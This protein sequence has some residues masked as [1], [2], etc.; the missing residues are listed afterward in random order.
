MSS[1]A[2]ARAEVAAGQDRRVV[3]AV[4]RAVVDA[5]AEPVDRALAGHLLAVLGQVDLEQRGRDELRVA[6][7]GEV[8]DAR[9][10]EVGPVVLAAAAVR[11]A[12][13]LAVLDQE[14]VAVVGDA[15]GGLAP[16]VVVERDLREQARLRVG[17]ARG[18]LRRVDDQQ[19]VL[20]RRLLLADVGAGA[21]LGR[22]AAVRLRLERPRGEQLRVGGVA[23]CRPGR[24][25]AC[26]RRRSCSCSRSCRRARTS[27][28]G[29]WPAPCRCSRA[30]AGGGSRRRRRRCRGSCC[31]CCRRRAACASR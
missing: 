16:L 31:G 25:S 22:R 30:A 8:E 2:H 6:L 1:H 11:R 26:R 13:A 28:R 7:V 14:R 24:R 5:V 12:R 9:V 27:P 23:R 17:L 10:A 19:L 15:V 18:D 20:R 21:V 29:P 3:E 4:G